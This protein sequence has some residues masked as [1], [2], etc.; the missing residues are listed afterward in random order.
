M[1]VFSMHMNMYIY[2]QDIHKHTCTLCLETLI[3]GRVSPRPA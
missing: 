2:K 3:F 1:C